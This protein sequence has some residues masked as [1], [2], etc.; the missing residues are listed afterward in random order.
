MSIA[1]I[2]MNILWTGWLTSAAAVSRTAP[3]W[4]SMSSKR[5]A[6]HAGLCIELDQWSRTLCRSGVIHRWFHESRLAG[7]PQNRLGLIGAAA[8]VRRNA[9]DFPE[10]VE[11]IHTV[12]C[13]PADLLVGDGVADTDV[14]KFKNLAD[15]QAFNCKCE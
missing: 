10:L 8:A 4:K 12:S 13:S 3:R 6:P 1:I 11:I 7:L 9:Q 5:K 2:I 15:F 14:H